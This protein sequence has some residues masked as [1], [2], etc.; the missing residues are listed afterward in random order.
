MFASPAL[1]DCYGW[2]LQHGTRAGEEFRDTSETIFRCR[3][4]EDTQ[5]GSTRVGTQSG[6]QIRLWNAI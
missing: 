6:V 2:N 3:E 5:S 1:S 4:M